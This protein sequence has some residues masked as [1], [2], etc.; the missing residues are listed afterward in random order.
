MYNCI[1]IDCLSLWGSFFWMWRWTR[2]RGPGF[3]EK[4]SEDPTSQKHT[5][6][7]NLQKIN[8]FNVHEMNTCIVFIELECE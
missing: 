4:V 3:V 5:K 7:T 2:I 8:Y 6:S 1:Y